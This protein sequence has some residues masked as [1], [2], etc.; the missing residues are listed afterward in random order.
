MPMRSFGACFLSAVTGSL[1]SVTVSR[2]GVSPATVRRAGR[3][4]VGRQGSG[5]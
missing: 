5:R 1:S 4:G 3:R 2:P